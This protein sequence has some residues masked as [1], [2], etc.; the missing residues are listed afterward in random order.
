[1]EAISLE[2]TPATGCYKNPFLLPSFSLSFTL[3]NATRNHE[4]PPHPIFFSSTQT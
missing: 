4:L 3:I 1:M 2:G